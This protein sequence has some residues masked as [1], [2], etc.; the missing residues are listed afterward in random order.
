ML[1]KTK[2]DRKQKARYAAN[3]FNSKV[4]ARRK[5]LGKKTLE[6]MFGILVG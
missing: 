6:P 1:T 4:K 2:E 5:A 3:A